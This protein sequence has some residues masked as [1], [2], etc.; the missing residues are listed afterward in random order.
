ME[1]LIL[2]LLAVVAIYLAVKPG[3]RVSLRALLVMGSLAFP[4]VM[5]TL[6]FEISMLGVPPEKEMSVDASVAIQSLAASIFWQV[7]FWPVTVGVVVVL[8]RMKKDRR[9]IRSLT[10]FYWIWAI[11]TLGLSWEYSVTSQD[12]VLGILLFCGVN[13]GFITAVLLV[14]KVGC[15]LLACYEKNMAPSKKDQREAGKGIS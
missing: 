2:P 13:L 12:M 14:W 5:S 4:M 6:L 8:S 9:F 15:A 3:P 10:V 11:I 7:Y 1:L